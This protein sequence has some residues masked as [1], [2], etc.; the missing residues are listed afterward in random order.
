MPPDQFWYCGL[1]T[2]FA[3][4]GSMC[5]T[6]FIISMT[7][8]RLY[9]I[10]APHK[11]AAVNTVTRTRTTIVFVLFA[12][13]LWTLPQLFFTDNIEKNCIPY[14]KATTTLGQIYFWSYTAFL[15]PRP[16]ILILTMNSVIIHILR[17]RSMS[18]GKRSENLGQGQGQGR[19]D[20]RISKMKS[21]NRQTFTMLLLVAF[22]YLLCS[23]PLITFGSIRLSVDFTQTAQDVAMAYLLNSVGEKLYYTNFG[24]NFY[25][26]VISGKKFRS[27]LGKMFADF[28]G[29]MGCMKDSSNSLSRGVASIA[30]TSTSIE[31]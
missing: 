8:D 6:M 18:L 11:A 5:S 10:I 24:I 26:Y 25:L 20:V 27:D 19:N 13:L 1:V 23:I 7:F 9:S 2:L 28:S 21:N 14:A 22:T 17:K 15:F 3:F 31:H 16:F 29:R 4:F 12:N 30:T